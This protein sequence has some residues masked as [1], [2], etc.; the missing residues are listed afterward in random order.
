MYA[1]SVPELMR[2]L[3]FMAPVIGATFLRFYPPNKVQDVIP[4]REG[5][6]YPKGNRRIFAN[7]TKD[8]SRTPMVVVPSGG[9]AEISVL[10]TENERTFIDFIKVFDIRHRKG[11]R[12]YAKI[13]SRDGEEVFST[14]NE[15]RNIADGN[16]R[17]VYQLTKVEKQESV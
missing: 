9:D 14:P 10:R 8:K 2:F 15:Y 12:G 16:I 3:G 5:R 13:T 1:E 4:G 7:L 6:E 11:Q 17:V